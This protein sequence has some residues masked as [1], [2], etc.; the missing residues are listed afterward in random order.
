MNT[1][2]IKNINDARHQRKLY[3]TICLTQSWGR[4]FPFFNYDSLGLG[5]LLAA[6]LGALL[7]D[8]DVEIINFNSIR[9]A[10]YQWLIRKPRYW[11]C[12]S[13]FRVFNLNNN[14]R[15]LSYS[16]QISSKTFVDMDRKVLFLSTDLVN[17]D[18]EYFKNF[19]QLNKVKLQ[20]KI[21]DNFGIRYDLENN[22]ILKK[23]VLG[24]HIRQGDFKKSVSET[25]GYKSNEQTKLERYLSGIDAIM[26]KHGCNLIYIF[27]DEEIKKHE[28]KQIVDLVCSQS[29]K[30]KVSFQ[31]ESNAIDAISKMMKC[32]VL[33]I[34]N[35]TFSFWASA[36]VGMKT[37]HLLDKLPYGS[38][39][40]FENMSSIIELK[41][42]N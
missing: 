14:V 8:E 24:V 28:K 42:T 11:Y 4:E 29:K 9:L 17:F 30:I 1:L 38:N 33:L 39:R 27:S 20:K 5:N 15:R 36:L 3:E 21:Y 6:Y 26:R 10:P 25:D 31:T 37:Y 23:N 16:P 41:E 13:S 12:R 2:D 40:Y 34:S 19:T 22:N 7:I 32:N 35:S 18:K